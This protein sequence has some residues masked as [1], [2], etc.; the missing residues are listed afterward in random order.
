MVLA[1]AGASFQQRS[2]EQLEEDVQLQQ[3][4][5]ASQREYEAE[6]HRR[7]SHSSKDPVAPVCAFNSQ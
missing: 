4:L 2:K 1:P 7:G 3:A 5:Q 6:Q